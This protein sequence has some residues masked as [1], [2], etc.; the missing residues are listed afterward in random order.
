MEEMLFNEIEGPV[1]MVVVGF[2]HMNYTLNIKL[3]DCMLSVPRHP[4]KSY[5]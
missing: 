1:R 4:N 2:K 5:Y 3:L